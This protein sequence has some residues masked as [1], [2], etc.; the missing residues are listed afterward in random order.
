[1]SA[2]IEPTEDCLRMVKQDSQDVYDILVKAVRNISF[3]IGYRPGRSFPCAFSPIGWPAN[4][5]DTGQGLI[6]AMVPE[7]GQKEAPGYE[8]QST[9]LAWNG[10]HVT[11]E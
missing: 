7:A 8:K 11:F 6:A 10:C 2:P 4:P 5:L 9:V 3:P 1:M